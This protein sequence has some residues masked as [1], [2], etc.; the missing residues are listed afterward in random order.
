MD[1]ICLEAFNQICVASKSFET[2]DYRIVGTLRNGVDGGPVSEGALLVSTCGVQE[3]DG[4]VN[5]AGV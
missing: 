3:A 1:R 5:L 2:C 4:V